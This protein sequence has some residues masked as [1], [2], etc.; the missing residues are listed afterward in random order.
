MN[1]SDEKKQ[2]PRLYLVVNKGLKLNRGKLAA[3]AAHAGHL[4]FRKATL[5]HSILSKEQQKDF[6]EWNLGSY[7]KIALGATESEFQTLREKNTAYIEVI[8]EGRTQIPKGTCTVLVWFP[9]KDARG[10]LAHL[11]LLN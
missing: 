9:S 1:P 4:F 10:E 8:D 5:E 6:Q 7:A 3:Q 11:K 2:E